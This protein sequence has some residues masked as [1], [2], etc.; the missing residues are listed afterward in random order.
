MSITQRIATV[1]VGAVVALGLGTPAYAADA[2]EDDVVGIFDDKVFVSQLDFAKAGDAFAVDGFN[3][4]IGDD[5]LL[6][7]DFEFAST[8]LF[9]DFDDDKDDDDKD[10]DK[11]DDFKDDDKK[12]DDK[13][14]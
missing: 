9:G 2:F 3:A 7:E 12:D 5:A 8:D 14:Y 1:A 4:L 11:K 13:K 6:F 10:D